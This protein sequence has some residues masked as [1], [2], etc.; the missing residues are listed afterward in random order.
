MQLFLR[1]LSTA[2]PAVKSFLLSTKLAIHHQLR[3]YRSD[4][5]GDD[6]VADKRQHLGKTQMEEQAAIDDHNMV[7]YTAKTILYGWS[8]Y[9]LATQQANPI[10][11]VV[12]CI[13]A[14]ETANDVFTAA[15]N[16]CAIF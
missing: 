11:V 3:K 6:T 5:F 1:I 8:A 4:P 9:N 2:Y 16:R 12:G 15:T 7:Y 13:A 14:V 10:D